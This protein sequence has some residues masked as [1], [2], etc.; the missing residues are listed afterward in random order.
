MQLWATLEAEAWRDYDGC[1]NFKEWV[2]WADEL[3]KSDDGV[4]SADS[5]GAARDMDTILAQ[6]SAPCHAVKMPCSQE[7]RVRH[8]PSLP[9][10]LPLPFSLPGGLLS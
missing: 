2:E 9:L 6:V 5:S 10:P 4:A 1:V 7:K 8:T 3:L